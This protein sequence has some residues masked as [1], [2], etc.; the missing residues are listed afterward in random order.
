M[1]LCWKKNTRICNF[2][3]SE[4][5]V[6]KCMR[7]HAK[8][9]FKHPLDVVCPDCLN[10]NPNFSTTEKRAMNLWDH[11]DAFIEVYNKMKAGNWKWIKNQR[12]KY[13]D[14]RIDMRDGG[15]IIKDSDGKRISPEMLAWQYTSE[16]PEPPES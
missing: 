1:R 16:N 3:L 13:V 2:S 5:T 11:V 8:F 4:V 12:C 6:D 15:C 7:C 9:E 14:L 10:K